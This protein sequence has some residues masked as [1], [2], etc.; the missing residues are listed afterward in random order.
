MHGSD[1][2]N[3]HF[4]LCWYL[5]S[6]WQ[7]SAAALNRRLFFEKIQ[8]LWKFVSLLLCR[9]DFAHM[10]TMKVEIFPTPS[11]DFIVYVLDCPNLSLHFSSF[12]TVLFL[13]CFT[14]RAFSTF[15]T[16]TYLSKC[17]MYILIKVLTLYQLFRNIYQEQAK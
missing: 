9:G 8:I 2:I 12:H 13:P 17:Q 3:F 1:R 7:H 11:S 14:F 4:L 15:Y 10:W 5:D 6:R 16:F